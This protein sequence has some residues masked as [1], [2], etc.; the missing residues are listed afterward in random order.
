MDPELFKQRFFSQEIADKTE[1]SF[2]E[3]NF[4]HKTLLVLDKAP[5]HL[6]KED[7]SIDGV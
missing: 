7:L 5:S 2:K 6:S 1:V 4:P 3:G